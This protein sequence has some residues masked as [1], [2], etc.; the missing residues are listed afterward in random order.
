MAAPPSARRPALALA[1]ALAMVAVALLAYRSAQTPLGVIRDCR[2]CS[3]KGQNLARGWVNVP[4]GDAW[5]V[6]LVPGG[7]AVVQGPARFE[8]AGGGRI[9]LSSG[10]VFAAATSGRVIVLL[11][12]DLNAGVEGATVGT[13]ASGTRVAMAATAEGN[14]VE[15]R[16]GQSVVAA[17]TGEK[18]LSSG[19]SWQTGKP[20]VV[21][22][23]DADETRW[24]DQ[25]T[26]P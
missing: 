16:A 2:S 19:E 26:R 15:V 4:P 22:Q 21:P 14:R 20:P 5:A 25:V 18:K 9:A 1:G 11:P 3:V 7:G 24:L 13:A 10:T 12:R 23:P 6:S 17:T 8:A